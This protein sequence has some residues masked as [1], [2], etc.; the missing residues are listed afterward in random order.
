[1]EVPWVVYGTAK[2]SATIRCK[3]WTSGWKTCRKLLRQEHASRKPKKSQ[4]ARLKLKHAKLKL[5]ERV[6]RRNAAP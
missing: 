1:M 6:M 3:N 2:T 5:I 4:H